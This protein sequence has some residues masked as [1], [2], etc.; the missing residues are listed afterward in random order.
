[1]SHFLHVPKDLTVRERALHCL[2]KVGMLDQFQSS[3]SC[4]DRVVHS[5]LA[6]ERAQY[7]LKNLDLTFRRHWMTEHFFEALPCIGPLLPFQELKASNFQVVNVVA[8][9]V[10]ANCHLLNTCPLNVNGSNCER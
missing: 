3:F 1:M 10:S 2:S 8:H 5:L 7:V 9:K 4:S 6:L